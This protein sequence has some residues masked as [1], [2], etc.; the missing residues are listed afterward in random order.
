MSTQNELLNEEME[1]EEIEYPSV[2]FKV[3]GVYYC[4]NSKYI[5]TLIQLPDFTGLPEASDDILGVFPYRDN[6]ITTFDIRTIFGLPKITEARNL[7]DADSIRRE[8]VIIL[9][10][11]NIG[12]AVDEVL[13]VENLAP[14]DGEDHMAALHAVNSSK[15]I[16]G[17]RKS[18]KLADD[19]ILEVDVPKILEG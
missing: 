3:D 11:V 10:D 19:I 17:V 8:M 14:I 16:L 9:S 6:F 7:Q 2:I 5:E 13:M 1:F 18:D 12:L 4:I 15:Y